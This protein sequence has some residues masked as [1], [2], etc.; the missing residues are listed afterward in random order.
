MLMSDPERV[1]RVC[2]SLR[3]HGFR[4][5][6]DDFGTGYSSLAY[7]TRLPI[8][9]L[10]VDHSFVDSLGRD[11]R[12][13]AITTAIVRMAQAL[14]LEVTGEGVETARQ[15]HLLRELGCELAQGFRFHRPLP[16]Q[17]ISRLLAEGAGAPAA[18]PPEASRLRTSGRGRSTPRP[19]GAPTT[20]QR[21]ADR[22]QLD[23]RR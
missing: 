4:L 13:T 2:T 9:G 6:V 21:P 14:S 23:S 20:R 7:L 12:S 1:M 10:K 18:D 16:A 17:A 8:A 11:E 19:A 5:T 15:A 22:A 3:R